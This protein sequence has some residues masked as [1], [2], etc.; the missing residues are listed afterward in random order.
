M[1][2]EFVG[3]LDHPPDME[4][5]T[6]TWPGL[7]PVETLVK[8][9]ILKAGGRT[10]TGGQVVRISVNALSASGQPHRAR[11]CLGVVRDTNSFSVGVVLFDGQGVG[12]LYVEWASP[13]DIDIVR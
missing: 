3:R 6:V 1:G 5:V 9:G 4:Q 8:R 10:F 11:G 13:H 7:K 12:T 2:E